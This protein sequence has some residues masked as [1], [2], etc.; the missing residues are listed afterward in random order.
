MEGAS[1]LEIFGVLVGET[2]HEVEFGEDDGAGV[3][4]VDDLAVGD[5]VGEELGWTGELPRPWG[6]RTP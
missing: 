5:A 3:D 4:G 6:S 1:N 2:R